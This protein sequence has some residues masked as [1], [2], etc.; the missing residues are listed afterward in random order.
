VAYNGWVKKGREVDKD[1]LS[2]PLELDALALLLI[3]ILPLVSDGTS[4]EDLLMAIVKNELLPIMSIITII[5]VTTMPN[6]GFLSTL[7]KIV[8]VPRINLI[9]VTD[10]RVSYNL[11]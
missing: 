2:S 8:Y 10:K 11:I 5:I 6:I 4:K 9:M 3:D 7:D 1:L